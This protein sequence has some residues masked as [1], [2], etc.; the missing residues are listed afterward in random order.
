MNKSWKGCPLCLSSAL[1][2]KELIALIAW[3]ATY[4]PK[5]DCMGSTL[6]Q[7]IKQADCK[8]DV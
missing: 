8:D 7:T 2:R 5:P 4:V 6:D 3:G 1:Y